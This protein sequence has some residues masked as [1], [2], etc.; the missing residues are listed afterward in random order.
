MG[1]GCVWDWDC[2]S[3]V[4]LYLGEVPGMCSCVVLYEDLLYEDRDAISGVVS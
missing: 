3:W 1:G 4:F 2:D